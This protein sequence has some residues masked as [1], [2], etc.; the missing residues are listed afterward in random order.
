MT[1]IAI[2]DF[3]ST[4]VEAINIEGEPWFNANQVA[5]ALGYVNSSQ[6]IQDNVSDKY[7][8][9]ID[10][11]RPGSKPLF[12]SEPGLYELM[13]KSKLPNAQRFR[14]WVLEKVL[15]QLRKA[16]QLLK[17][18]FTVESD[19]V[20]ALMARLDKFD[21]MAAVGQEHQSFVAQQT[22]VNPG[23]VSLMDGARATRSL[24]SVKVWFTAAEWAVS[25]GY[26]LDVRQKS[27]LSTQAAAIYKNFKGKNPNLN[28]FGGGYIYSS[29][30][31]YILDHAMYTCF[32]IV[33]GL[34]A[35]IQGLEPL[36]IV[37]LC[38]CCDVYISED[39]PLMKSLVKEV[40]LGAIRSED[41]P[42]HC[43]YS[44]SKFYPTKLLLDFLRLKC[45]K[46]IR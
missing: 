6:A 20:K 43:Q 9:Q 44:C 46:G 21:A 24:P 29:H 14:D 42:R 4:T 27:V 11:G 16:N 1:S 41:L 32:Q 22:V 37:E 19:L 45:S 23:L 18:E 31:E 35:E 34:E 28:E 26:A 39:N 33:G 5:T 30:E 12:L 13:M 10:L 2:F 3:D 25:K 8:C 17:S 38:E 36:S 40:L 7:I 15:P